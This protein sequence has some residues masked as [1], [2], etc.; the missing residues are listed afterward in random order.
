MW[1]F[2][3]DLASSINCQKDKY[4]VEVKPPLNPIMYRIHVD[5][6]RY[7]KLVDH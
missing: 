5:F 6:R 3:Q 1:D 7:K 4:E 2:N